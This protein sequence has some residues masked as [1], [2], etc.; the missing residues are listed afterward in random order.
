MRDL[1]NLARV[2]DTIEC[3][4]HIPVPHTITCTLP[5]QRCV[6]FANERLMDQKSGWRLLSTDGADAAAPSIPHRRRGRVMTHIYLITTV[7]G[8]DGTSIIEAHLE[9]ASAAARVTAANEYADLAPE[10]PPD[11]ASEQEYAAFVDADVAW[12]NAH[13]FGESA[14]GYRDQRYCVVDIP[15]GPASPSHRERTDP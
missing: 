14:C 15:I 13:P 7:P 11:D 4:M 1:P 9:E 6:D 8:Y 10:F 3:D 2:G 5:N 12:R